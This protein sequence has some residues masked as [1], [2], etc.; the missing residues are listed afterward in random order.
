MHTYSR[1]RNGFRF[2]LNLPLQD[3]LVARHVD[4]HP[5]P[6][7]VLFFEHVNA[8]KLAHAK[9][10]TRLLPGLEGR[11]RNA[12]PSTN[13]LFRYAAV[14]LAQGTS[15]LRFRKRRLLHR[16]RL[17]CSFLGDRDILVLNA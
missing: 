4:H 16:F 9:V 3:V 7:C 17:L 14:Q 10:C 5:L 6:V 13:V 12:H 1:R 15:N 8:R 11:P 2:F